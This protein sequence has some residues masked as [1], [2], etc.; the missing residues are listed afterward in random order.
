MKVLMQS[1]TTLFSVPGGDTIQILKTKEYL[2]KLGI[3]VDISTELEPSLEEYDLVHIFN[4][5]RPQELYLQAKNAKRQRKKLVL[6]PI[7]VSYMD[8]D[9]VG[10]KGLRKILANILNPSQMEYLKI[11]ARA[12]KNSEFHK[13]TI[14]VI[15]KG[16]KKLQKNIL[17]LT[18]IILP[19]SK[20]E[21][22]RI[23]REFGVRDLVFVIVP[24]GVD[25]NLFGNMHP[26][27]KNKDLEK[28]KDCV[29]CV[30]RIEGPKNQLNLVRAMM[31][32][33]YKLV[34]VGA[35]APNH[36][37]YFGK[38]KKEASKAKNIYLLGE[39]EYSLLHQ[40]YKLAKVHVLASWFETTGLSSL[41][42]GIMGCNLVITDKGDTREYFRDYAI[43]C[44]PDSIESI[45]EAVVKAY[46]SPFNPK[47][48]E[49]ILR[50]FTWEK[51]AIKT[52]EAYNKI[53]R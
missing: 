28:F 48:R 53:L 27:I 35:V 37:A 24:N 40:L 44:D 11:I 22:N 2:E 42:A 16:Y 15:V 30:A 43:Y 50:N 5:I 25:L 33:P 3:E 1:R 23:S 39:I 45:Q 32:L 29:L 7:Y 34:L 9:R 21:M 31:N 49:L 14:N 10:S 18:D 36:K 13:G 19:N 52:L 51:T 8:Y 26:E 6:S 17:N 38:I 4:L 20:S 41:E 46:E 12:I 47:L